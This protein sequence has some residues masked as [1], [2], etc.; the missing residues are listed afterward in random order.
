MIPTF[1]EFYADLVEKIARGRTAE[2]EGD[3]IKIKMNI[4]FDRTV[5]YQDV[6]DEYNR[7]YPGKT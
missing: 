7:L 1:E 3:H 5:V 6:L 4:W 2:V